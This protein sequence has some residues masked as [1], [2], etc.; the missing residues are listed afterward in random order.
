MV[1]ADPLASKLAE[2]YGKM[3]K[4]GVKI[5]PKPDQ[6]ALFLFVT[7]T[8]TLQRDPEALANFP[9]G[10]K[11]VIS[12]FKADMP[13][14]RFKFVKSGERLGMAFDGLVFVNDHWVL[15]PRPWR[16]LK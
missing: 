3:M 10:Y 11:K 14:A 1:Y 4:P 8:K 6:D 15:M 16:A 12:Y 9:G 5:G 7:T 13:I 2:G